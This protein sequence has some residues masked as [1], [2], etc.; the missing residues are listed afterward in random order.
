MWRVVRTAP[1]GGNTAVV[2]SAELRFPSPIFAQRMRLG[3]FVDAGQ[4]WERGQ[5]STTIHGM[6]ITPGV[7]LRFATP[8][9]PVRVDAAY[10]GY[11]AERGP[12]LY[13]PPAPGAITKIRNSY[14]PVRAGKTFWQ[15]LVI[16]FAVGQ[17][18]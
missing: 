3:L 9:G 10:N 2:L 5:D 6:R 8:L 18:F 16:Q 7:G 12:L 14:P 11:Q 17:A 1:T 4:V 13:Q 15:K